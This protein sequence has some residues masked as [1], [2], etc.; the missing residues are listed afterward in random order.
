MTPVDNVPTNSIV[1]GEGRYT[2]IMY[3]LNSIPMH[4]D[5]VE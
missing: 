1:D 2:L 4:F 3:V 5:A